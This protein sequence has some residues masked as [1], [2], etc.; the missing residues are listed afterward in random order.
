MTQRIDARPYEQAMD[1]RVEAFD[2][3]KRGQAAPGPDERLLDRVSCELVVPEM[4]RAA[5]SSRATAAWAS[6]A[7]AS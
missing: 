3:A 6:S 1:P 7:K 4:S 2:V 5:A